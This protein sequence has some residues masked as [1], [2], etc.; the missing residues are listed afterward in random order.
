MSQFPYDREADVPEYLQEFADAYFD[1]PSEGF[2][3]ASDCDGED[4]IIGVKPSCNESVQRHNQI[5]QD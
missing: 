2:I 5:H 3:I 1:V 4:V